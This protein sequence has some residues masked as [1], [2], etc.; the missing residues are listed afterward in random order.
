MKKSSGKGECK[1]SFGVRGIEHIGITVP[2]MEE[3]TIFFQKVFEAE[4]CYDV[5]T[6]DQESQKGPQAE[7]KLALSPGAEID[8]IRLL[9]IGQS[10]NIE[11]FHIHAGIRKNPAGLADYGL[12]HLAF[13]VDDLKNAVQRLT[14]AGGDLL[15]APFPLPGKEAGPANNT[16]YARAPWGT[17]IELITY[18]NGIVYPSSSKTKRWTPPQR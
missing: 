3:A 15:S 16:V 10:S 9:R 7:K 2:D 12:T 8:H 11:L 4:I 17:L 5:L 6:P 18:P 1:M 14:D 13:Y